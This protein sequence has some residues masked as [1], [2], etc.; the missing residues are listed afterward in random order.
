ML[1]KSLVTVDG[2]QINTT[3]NTVLVKMDKVESLSKGG[4]II[5]PDTAKL[6]T[7]FSG[8]VV[9][10]SRTEEKTGTI[11]VGDRVLVSKNEKRVVPTDD[12]KSEYRLYNKKSILYVEH[13]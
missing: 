10:I 2:Q 1:E 12:E 11:K 9:A 4:L 6:R 13:R 7:D 3:V 8:E 5:I